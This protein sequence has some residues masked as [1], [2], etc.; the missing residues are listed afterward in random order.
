VDRN[1][2]ETLEILEGVRHPV[3]MR[4]Y[5]KA[6]YR[7]VFEMWAMRD[8][9]NIA[10]KTKKVAPLNKPDRR[11]VV[12][13]CHASKANPEF[14]W[15]AFHKILLGQMTFFDQQAFP[16]H[17]EELVPSLLFLGKDRGRGHEV[18]SRCPL[19]DESVKF[20]EALML[21][22]MVRGWTDVLWLGRAGDPV[23]AEVW[24]D[25]IHLTWG[26]NML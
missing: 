14:S 20:F 13:D 26:A 5:S 7:M 2:S 6:R 10:L 9:A 17:S 18:R 15:S 1:R 22:V 3:P 19:E 24:H 11:A 4:D 21:D 23:P 8:R 12:H 25:G 16:Q